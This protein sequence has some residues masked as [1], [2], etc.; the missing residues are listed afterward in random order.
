[1]SMQ[2]KLAASRLETSSY[3]TDVKEYTSSTKIPLQCIKFL[4]PHFHPQLFTAHQSSL[5]L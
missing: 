4:S 3:D 5:P 1:M 2:L